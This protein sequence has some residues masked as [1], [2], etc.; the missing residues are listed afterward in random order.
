MGLGPSIDGLPDRY[1]RLL[2]RAVA[3]LGADNRVKA[4]WVS[5]SWARGDADEGSDLDLIVATTDEG[6]AQFVG[7]AREWWAE[8]TPTVLLDTVPHAANVWYSVTP[9][10]ARLDM[11]IEKE[12]ALESSPHRHRLAIVDPGGLSSRIPPPPKESGPDQGGVEWRIKELFRALCLIEVLVAR[13]DWLLGVQ[14]CALMQRTLADLY[15]AANGT[16][17]T[18]GVKHYAS[19]LTSEQRST[20]E[21]LPPIAATRQAVIAGHQAIFDAAIS[22][23]PPL[24]DAVGV[25]WPTGLERTARA[26]LADADR[27]A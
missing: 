2:D 22:T 11:V 26:Q 8:I 21:A 9:D 27:P 12:S 4:I 14:G 5:G 1:A 16:S 6:Y 25:M 18:D 3:V 17:S 10:G 19:R 23:V 24:A 20:L 15:A 7:A 13:Q